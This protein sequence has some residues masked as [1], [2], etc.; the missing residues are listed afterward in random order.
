MSP[1]DRQGYQDGAR[2]TEP[3]TVS[4]KQP[5]PKFPDFPIFPS[6]P[7]LIHVTK[8]IFKDDCKGKK[9]SRPDTDDLTVR[10]EK[11]VGLDACSMF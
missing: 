7:E 10:E 9:R 8:D 1:K 6:S 4:K 2:P 3:M 11:K 5:F